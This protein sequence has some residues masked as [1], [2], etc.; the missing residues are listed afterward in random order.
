MPVFQML[1]GIAKGQDN[2]SFKLCIPGRTLNE[3]SQMRTPLW[4]PVII[5]RPAG[6]GASHSIPPMFSFHH[7][8]AF[9]EANQTGESIW[10]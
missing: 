9:T 1:S 4:S 7:Q 10:K 2:M 8:P 6:G 5:H 3:I